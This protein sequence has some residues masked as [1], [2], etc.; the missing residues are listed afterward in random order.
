M[1]KGGKILRKR[2]WTFQ[3]KQRARKAL[4]KYGWKSNW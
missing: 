3:S 2:F 4:E 1:K